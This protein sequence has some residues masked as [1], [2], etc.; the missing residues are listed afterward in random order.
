[1]YMRKLKIFII[2]NMVIMSFC[3]CIDFPI[4]DFAYPDYGKIA[5]LITDWTE[6]GDNIDIPE[7]YTV[8]IS[9][10]LNIL[11]GTHHPIDHLFPCGKHVINIWNTTDHITVSDM[12]ATAEYETGKPGWF[13]SGRKEAVIEKDM[14]QSITVLMQQQVRQL[15]FE[16]EV[17]DNDNYRLTGVSATLSGV[18]GTLNIDDGTHGA[19][20]I[21]ALTFTENLTDSKWKATVRL[22]GVTGN[23][24]TLTLTMNFAD[25]HPSMFTSDLSSQLASFNDNKKTPLMLYARFN[26]TQTDGELTTNITDW[27]SEGTSTGDAD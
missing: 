11:S 12:M 26:G 9:D 22:L 7:H 15:T 23:I 18:A 25:G 4:Y 20:T 17:A 10:Y 24:Q 5:F 13:F 2:M 6:R 16:L 14:E 3:G 21:I 1:M 27:D 8:K 19:P